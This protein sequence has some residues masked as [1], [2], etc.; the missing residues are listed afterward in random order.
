MKKCALFFA[1]AAMT[2]G[3]FA[4]LPSYVMFSSTGPDLYADG[5]PVLDGEVYALVWTKAGE[6]FAGF[7]AN[8]TL[9]NPDTSKLV[10]AAP[11][12]TGYHCPPVMYMLTGENSDLDK[13]GSFSVYLMDTRVKTAA[14]TTTVA[15]VD[16]N[17]KVVVDAVNA[18]TAVAAEVKG[19]AYATADAASATGAV[20]TAVPADAPQPTITAVKVVGG[21]VIVKVANT[22]PYLQYGISAGKTPSQLDQTD[23]VDGVN[24]TAEGLTLIVDDPAENRFFKV[25]RK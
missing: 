21:Q 10:S 13:A 4:G 23:L 16:E 20:A 11:I 6:T 2:A 9:V 18:T 12:A 25:I 19:G 17:G 8:G 24:G 15:G 14:G 5:T 3:A 22:V 1:A 7:N